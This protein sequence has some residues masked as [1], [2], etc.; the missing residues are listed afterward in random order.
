MPSLG[1]LYG[2]GVG[3]GG[4][5]RKEA[6]CLLEDMNLELKV[7]SRISQHTGETYLQKETSKH[8]QKKRG[9][10]GG[11][12]LVALNSLNSDSSL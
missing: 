10:K 6:L 7:S 9:E 3:G 5:E 8:T 12:D 11:S 2:S 1:M 4:Q